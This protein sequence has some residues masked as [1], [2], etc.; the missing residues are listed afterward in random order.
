MNLLTSIIISTILYVGAFIAYYVIDCHGDIKQIKTD[1]LRDIKSM[2]CTEVFGT[3]AVWFVFVLI[4]YLLVNAIGV[5]VI[6]GM[7]AGFDFS[8]AL[9]AIM[10]TLFYDPIAQ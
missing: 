7:N 6:V 3:I 1:L 8:S 4:L 5:L 9:D 10:A 2:D